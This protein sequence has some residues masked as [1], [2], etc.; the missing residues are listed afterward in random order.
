MQTIGPY[1]IID[2]LGVNGRYLIYSV[3]A[4]EGPQKFLIKTLRPIEA[5]KGDYAQLQHEA[6]LLKRLGPHDGHFPQVVG[7]VEKDNPLN[8]IL[9]NDGFIFLSEALT[10]KPVDLS[11]FF[12]LAIQLSKMLTE[13]HEAGL[14]F[15]N[16]NPQSIWMRP[17]DNAVQIADFSIATELTRTMVPGDPPRLLQGNLE[18]I[19]PEQTGR[20][21]RPLTQAADLYSLGILFYEY[22]TGAVPF[23]GSEPMT[24]IFGHIATLP[25]DLKECDSALPHSLC[26]IVMKLLSKMAEDRYKS[27]LGLTLDLER[28]FKE[29]QENKNISA[30]FP[31][32][33]H[34]IA[35]RLELPS[36][37]YGRALETQILFDAFD[38]LCQKHQ[39]TLIT[40]AGYSGA[41]KTSLVR[42]LT[43]RIALSKG[44]L[45]AGQFDK[46]QRSDSYE[47]LRQALDKLIRYQLSLP[48]EE[49][50]QFRNDL[51]EQ[52]GGVLRVITDF[53]PRLKIIVGTP[54]P[55]PEVG[56]EAT[57]NRFELSIS[58]FIKLIA[59]KRPLVLFLDNVQWANLSLFDLIKKLM[60]SADIQNMLLILSYRSNEVDTTHPLTEFLYAIELHQPIKNILVEGLNKEA[61]GE[62]LQNMLYLPATELQFLTELMEKKTEGN[63]FFLLMLLEELYRNRFLSFSI[64]K[65]RWV[66]DEKRITQMSLTDNVLDFVA[67]RIAKLTDNTKDSLHIASCMGSTFNLADLALAQKEATLLVARN[68]HAAMQESLIVPTQLKDEWAEGVSEE[69]L[70]KREYRFQHDKIQQACYELKPVEE[71]KRIHLELARRWAAS[72]QESD[73]GTR[74][75][76]IAN[77]FNKGLVYVTDLQ[78]K[79]QIAQFNY[80][81]AEVALASSAYDIAYQYGSIAKMLL[82]KT[83]WN[84]DYDFCYQV[85]FTYIQT[86]FLSKHFEE[87]SL[88]TEESFAK[89]KSILEKVTL[90]RLKGDLNRATEGEIENNIQFY[91]EGFRLL[92]YPNIAKNPNKWD[93]IWILLRFKWLLTYQ[94]TPLENLPM[95]T[96]K[97]EELFKLLTT[98]FSH[99]M[100]V[101]GNI[102]RYVYVLMA[103]GVEFFSEQSQNSR[104][105]CYLVNAVLFPHSTFAHTLYQKSLKLSKNFKESKEDA[106]EYVAEI[107]FYAAW[108]QPWAKLTDCLKKAA[109]VGEKTGDLENTSWSLLFQILFEVH[110]TLPSALD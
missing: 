14:V 63:P 71:T 96:T 76:S 8:L 101:R 85:Y 3:K 16:I 81:A 72:Y 43:P 88:A 51:L 45:A 70:S 89:T 9:Q 68:L 109:Y 7:W 73:P 107:L 34:D 28:A 4:I 94:Q 62:L 20:M 106:A 35:T 41:G 38:T 11:L 65:K 77:Q 98:R 47:G 31:L 15:K 61:L 25:K 57:K 27:A 23:T 92:G 12:P 99:E 103:S 19:A 53:V 58:R 91:A 40:V 36:R 54:E 95:I 74:I 17:T 39:N 87:A 48:E 67:K 93:L 10:Q 78:E 5:E 102:L 104:I 69:E 50:K 55:L 59:S 32:G 2:T 29:W 110:L 18:Y 90:L 21:N 37:L 24:I 1:E 30:V 108:Y 100:L 13:I 60:L 82:P 22:L 52:M 80:K 56:I 26:A 86:A 105:S 75:M 64:E 49:Y 33:E 42:E 97:K 46:F 44:F 66:W 79:K 84:E 83:A 6:A